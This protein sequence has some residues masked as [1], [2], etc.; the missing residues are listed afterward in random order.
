MKAVRLHGREDLRIDDVAEP[1]VGPGE[2]MLKNAYVGICGSDVHLYFAPEA[3]PIDVFSPHP[4]TGA[5]LPQTLG[6]EFSG[7]VVEVGEGV[8][9]VEVGDRGAVFPIAYSCGECVACRKGR[10][11]S[12][13]LMAS[14]GANADGGGM[15]E[16]V[17]V[18]ASQFHR[19]PETVDLRTASLVEPMTVAWHG[20]DRSRAQAGETALIAGA[21]PIGIGAWYAFR[22]HGV[23][24]ILVSEPSADRRAKIAALGAEVIDPTTEDLGAAIAERT[25]G[26]GVDIVYDA[27]GVPAALSS[28]LDNLAP[29]GRVVLQSPHERGFE[30]Q[31]S[32]MMMGEFEL[33]GSVGYT[34]ADFDGVIARMAAGEYDTTGWTEEMDLDDAVEAI[35]R[36]H[37]GSGTKIALRVS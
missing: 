1:T 34:P 37:A 4:V 35:H 23:T 32:A 10:P 12:C 20:V 33:I 27:A 9:G 8:T 11:T 7:T 13:R 31:P 17:T 29:G 24:D 18:G 25:D 15:A 2:I 3:L 5:H 14:T 30:I 6:H 26:D 19:V 22:A 21:G 16:F 28:G 36:L